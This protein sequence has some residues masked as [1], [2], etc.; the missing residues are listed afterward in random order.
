MQGKKT[1]TN[2]KQQQSIY[3]MNGNE[4]RAGIATKVDTKPKLIK[5]D[6]GGHY[7]LRK[8]SINKEY[9]II[10]NMYATNVGDSNLI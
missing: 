10:V 5:R 6:K 9:T 8:V 2:K 3:K 4:N 1:K 7:T